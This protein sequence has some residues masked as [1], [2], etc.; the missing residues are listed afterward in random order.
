MTTENE[1]LEMSDHFKNLMEKKN[2]EMIELKKLICKIYGLVC[3]E[4]DCIDNFGVVE[5]IRSICSE[6]IEEILL[7]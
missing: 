6:K 2:E 1:L 7:S 3:M 4:D 5:Y